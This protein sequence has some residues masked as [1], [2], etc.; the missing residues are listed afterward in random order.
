MA[1]KLVMIYKCDRCSLEGHGSGADHEYFP[2]HG[3]EEVNW[4]SVG[5]HGD[6]SKPLVKKHSE[7][8]RACTV[9]V[10]TSIDHAMTP[11]GVGGITLKTLMKG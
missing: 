11:A 8:C 10:G 2:P 1:N 9:H 6:M 3:W 7:L 5:A 4:Y